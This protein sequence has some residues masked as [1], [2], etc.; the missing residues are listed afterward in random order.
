MLKKVT[1]RDG[2]VVD[3]SSKKVREAVWKSVQAV[4]GT[5]NSHAV[6]IADFVVRML[7]EKFSKKIPSVEDV[8][9]AVEKVLI[10]HGH[11]QTAKAFILY[12][13][14]RQTLREAKSA[15]GVAD[16]LKLSFDALSILSR[17]KMLK[18]NEDGT[19]ETPRQLFERVAKAL[20]K[21]EKN[22]GGDA[23]AVEREFVSLLLNRDVMP[24]VG[25]LQ[26]AGTGE[27]LTDGF[28][29]PIYDDIASLFGTLSQAALLH[30]NQSSGFGLGFSFSPIRAKGS[31]VRGG[32]RA[33]GPVAFLRLY[34]RAL[35]QI[36]AHGTNLAFLN[37]HHPDIVDFITAKDSY[38]LQN[39]GISV[40]LTREFMRAVDEDKPYKLINPNTKQ[41]VTELRARSVLDMIATISWRTG[42]PAVVF[43]D[44]LNKAPT[45]PFDD[46]QIEATTPTG[47]H[48]LFPH[49]S[50]F[51][52]SVN[53][54]N[55]VA[56]G[57][58]D[59]EKLRKSVSGAVRMLDNAIDVCNYP[60][61]ELDEAMKMTRR[62]GVGVIGWADAMIQLGLVYAGEEAIKLS[63][64]L[65]KFV[66]SAAKEASMELAKD[67]GTFG[68]YKKS[69]YAKKNEKV[70]NSSRTTITAS[71]VTS[72][73][74]GCS[75]GIEPY[76]AIS[77]MKRTP[78]S[79]TFEV[80]PIFEE[81]AKR[82]EFY[83]EELMKKIA[84]AGSVAKVREI[85][86]KWRKLFVTS[87]DCNV[88]EHLA[89]QAAFQKHTDNAVSKTINLPAYATIH[90]V[91]EI[92]KK[93]YELG[94][95][96]V[97]IYREGSAEQ[98]IHSQTN[99]RR[100]RKKLE[101]S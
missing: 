32:G 73:I 43:L 80:I 71:G 30:K 38:D 36:N 87:Y 61:A 2:R 59:W 58:F 56:S 74:A 63:E 40:L 54:S 25:I 13:Q 11:S 98:L 50:C 7:N 93:A 85:P 18:R 12:R 100:S 67:R 1:K 91:E 10:E 77:Y 23:K 39:F 78:T 42:D 97:H 48:P 75:Q 28:V 95:K 55:H 64:K 94:C 46:V 66:S 53:L 88:G 20:S 35:S 24:S 65:M 60:S 57:D 21:A 68:D 29:L 79:E 76:F 19:L 9:D 44:N 49:E 96:S 41:V 15:L 72:A 84:L 45:N 83:S 52:A 101:V 27:T 90:E 26:H 16:D 5:D 8:Q 34:D 31:S 4:G 92:Y 33:G 62:I 17:Y 86:E 14:K 47:E 69:A 37:V 6:E 22:Y 89:V 3:F 51:T 82:E 70:R 81:V 99:G